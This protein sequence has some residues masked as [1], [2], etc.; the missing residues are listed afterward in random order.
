L[1]IGSVYEYSGAG[2]VIGVPHF[3]GI[4]TARLDDDGVAVSKKTSWR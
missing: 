1:A 2:I 4:E 3:G